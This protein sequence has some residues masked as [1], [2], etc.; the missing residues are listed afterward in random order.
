[1]TQAAAR[2]LDHEGA[3]APHASL[4]GVL[5]SDEVYELLCAPLSDG[6]LAPLAS[7]CVRDALALG[8][9]ATDADMSSLDTPDRASSYNQATTTR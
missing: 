8:S 9:S 3:D 6:A 4:T 7:T 2:V 1:M 5:L